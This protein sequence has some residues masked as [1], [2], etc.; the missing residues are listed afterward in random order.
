MKPV[1]G[2][3]LDV[4]PGS[5]PDGT[6]RRAQNWIYGQT[7]DG[8]FQEPG[9]RLVE[10]I[11][12]KHLI[13]GYAFDDDTFVLFALSNTATAN[14]GS[15][16]YKY[17]LST[18]TLT[19]VIADDALAFTRDS[20]FDLATYVNHDGQKVV[21]FTDNVNPVRVVNIDSPNTNLDTNKMYPDFD[22][23]SITAHSTIAGQLA[24]GTHFFCARYVSAEGEFTPF[25]NWPPSLRREWLWVCADVYERR[26]SLS[27]F[28]GWHTIGCRQLY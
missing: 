19:T 13:A 4:T 27:V 16:I 22:I 28:G 25:V 12:S 18:D 3:N 14:T 11:A 6:Y 1:K 24:K 10:T 8:L 5:Q 2:M 15:I 7:L 21:I 26:Y 17:E 20:V 9:T 23:P